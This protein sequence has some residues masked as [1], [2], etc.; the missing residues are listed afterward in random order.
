M[1]GIQVSIQPSSQS[2]LWAYLTGSAH[3]WSW[4]AGTSVVWVQLWSGRAQRVDS[5]LAGMD[6]LL[7][8]IF[9]GIFSINNLFPS[10]GNP[11]KTRFLQT[12][13]TATTQCG[14]PSTKQPWP[15]VRAVS[16]SMQPFPHTAICIA[17]VTP[18]EHPWQHR[19]SS[20]VKCGSPW[21]LKQW[22]L[23]NTVKEPVSTI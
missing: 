22:A 7:K 6:L 21:S 4:W 1:A 10:Y 5:L 19:T 20:S 18:S 15:G 23:Q 14:P 16:R 12:L 17:D 2:W 8:H 13:Y 11:F 3:P 9:K